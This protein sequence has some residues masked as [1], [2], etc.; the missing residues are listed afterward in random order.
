MNKETLSVVEGSEVSRSVTLSDG[1]VVTTHECLTR[2]IGAVLQL[3][4]AF[5][6]ATGVRRFSDLQNLEETITNPAAV[7]QSFANDLD[8]L[9]A[10]V[11]ALSDCT[12][13]D[14]LDMRLDD[15]LAIAVAAGRV[16][17]D[18]FLQKI[19]PNVLSGLPEQTDQ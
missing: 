2:D 11:S 10:A 14:L 17:K 7:L 3:V 5:V 16:N 6:R 15:A 9:W 4:S 19:L 1:K 8:S 18:F 12:V 13:D